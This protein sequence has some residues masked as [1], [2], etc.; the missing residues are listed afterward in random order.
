MGFRKF[1]YF[2][3]YRYRIVKWISVN[4]RIW[5]KKITNL[6]TIHLKTNQTHLQDKSKKP[7]YIQKN[8]QP[9]LNLIHNYYFHL[10]KS[11][12]QV[13]IS[14]SQITLFIKTSLNY[15]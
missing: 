10:I 1:R 8:N 6:E 9:T 14:H 13:S 3:V 4:E 5:Q 11:N 15:L 7:Q 2:Q 12:L